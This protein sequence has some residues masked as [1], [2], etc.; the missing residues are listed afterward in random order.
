MSNVGGKDKWTLVWICLT[1]RPQA[2]AVAAA[3]CARQRDE[4]PVA[5][6]VHEAKWCA[7]R[8]RSLEATGVPRLN[9]QSPFELRWRLRAEVRIICCFGSTLD[10]PHHFGL[11]DS[12]RYQNADPLS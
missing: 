11:M 8:K 6:T 7:Q 5:A 2:V 4:H 1:D 12:R 10:N 9:A 3:A